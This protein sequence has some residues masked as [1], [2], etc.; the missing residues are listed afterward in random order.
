M[1][2]IETLAEFFKKTETEI[3]DQAPEGVC[4]L[5]WG[6]QEYNHKIRKLY[7]DKQIDVNNHQDSYML[8]Q[9]FVK[10]NLD[11]IQPL[12]AETKNCPKCKH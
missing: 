10:Q 4:S 5:C 7:A 2:L 8:I 1:N 3:K 12:E 9:D 11:G 6:Y